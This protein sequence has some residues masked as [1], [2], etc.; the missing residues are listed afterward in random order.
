MFIVFTII[1]TTIFAAFGYFC[2]SGVLT[3]TG[4]C[5]RLSSQTSCPQNEIL[6]SIT[7]VQINKMDCLTFC[8][9]LSLAGCCS[10][11]QMGGTCDFHQGSSFSHWPLPGQKWTGLCNVREGKY[12]RAESKP[13]PFSEIPSSMWWAAA[14]LHMVGYGEIY[15]TSVTGRIVGAIS[16]SAGLL[17]IAFPLIVLS[18]NFTVAILV[19]RY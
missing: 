10:F 12:R 9:E 7:S 6:D 11:D 5:K 17:W 2:E 15:P 13:S 1:M 18:S 8:E 4:N 19:F 14:T 16:S 3:V